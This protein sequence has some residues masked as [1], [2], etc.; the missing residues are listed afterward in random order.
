[1]AVAL[2]S[3]H[4]LLISGKCLAAVSLI[5]EKLLKQF[6][7]MW[8]V[9]AYYMLFVVFIGNIGQIKREC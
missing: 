2:L 7:D 4:Y 8:L 3:W 9:Y 6:K 1:M 5:N